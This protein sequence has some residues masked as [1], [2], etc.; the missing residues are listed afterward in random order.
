MYFTNLNKNSGLS[1]I[2]KI[3]KG[4]MVIRFCRKEVINDE[5]LNRHSHLAQK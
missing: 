5:I 3:W 1:D 4:N 2:R